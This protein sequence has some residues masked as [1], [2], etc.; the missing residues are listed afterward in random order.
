MA[1]SYPIPAGEAAIEL[2]FKNSRFIGTA[3]VAATVEEA[4]VFIGHMRQR[5][6]DAGHHVYAFAVGYGAS[7]THGMSDDGEPSGTAGRPVLAVVR[8][9]ELGDVV[10]VITRYFGG[11]KLGTG[12]LVKA[13]TETAQAVLAA[14]P[15][16]LK[17]D[18]VAARLVLPYEFHKPCRMLVETVGG[19]IE[20][21]NFAAAVDLRFQVSAERLEELREAV[22]E[23]TS[24]RVSLEAG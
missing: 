7:V 5:Y 4:R 3:S 19:K 21:E 6:A 16:Q 20:E 10:V 12:G 8:G 15:R 13:Y 17:V 11:T 9:A 22:R 18:L 23:T 1:A 2:R 14:V 24:G